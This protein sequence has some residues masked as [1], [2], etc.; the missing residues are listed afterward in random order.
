MD[1][2][3]SYTSAN[4]LPI[5][6]IKDEKLIKSINKDN[7]IL[8]RHVQLVPTNACN[9]HCS[10]CSCDDVDKKQRLNKAEL[11]EIV[12]TL[13]DLET[14]GVT[15]TGGGEPTVY[16]HINYL[17]DKLHSKNIDTGLVT[18]GILAK[19]IDR[20]N[21]D[22]MTWARVSFSDERKFDGAFYEGL[23]H[24]RKSEDLDLAFSY[25]V[26]DKINAH[27]IISI[28]EYANDNNL[29]HVRMVGDILNPS[30]ERM[31]T[32]KYILKS[33]GISDNKV[34]YQERKTFTR[35]DKDCNI[36]LL[37]P[38]I[39]PDGYVYPCCGVQYAIEGNA[40]TFPLN[41]RMG[42]YKDLPSIIKEQKN[43]DGSVC[44]KCYYQEY[45]TLLKSLKDRTEHM[46]FV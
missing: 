1:K 7:I 36:S 30:K 17:I 4:A 39:A 27:N 45:N 24:L 43:F 35:G 18:N 8:P 40:K 10:F 44:D 19:N 2:K 38:L 5:K 3:T 29:T 32:V 31:N 9:L 23:S 26:T 28:V 20:A 12:N 14:V 22:A 13:D 6:V 34:I 37:K 25:V 16:K 11:E 46:R 41:M 42:H 33:R 21:L 15:I